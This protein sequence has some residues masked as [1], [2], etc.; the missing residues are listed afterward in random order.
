MDS[1][2]RKYS[3]VADSWE[4]DNESFGSVYRGKFLYIMNYHI[5][6]LVLEKHSATRRQSLTKN[7]N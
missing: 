2:G 3:P 1:L 7:C 6:L 4:Q 5:D